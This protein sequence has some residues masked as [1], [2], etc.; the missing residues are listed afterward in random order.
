[1]KRGAARARSVLS[2]AAALAFPYLLFEAQ[3]LRR[4][5]CKVVLPDL[6]EQLEGLVIVQLSDMHVGFQPSLNLRALRKAFAIARAAAPDLIVITGDLAC[7]AGRLDELKAELAT[8]AAPL[9][10]FAV[11]GNHDHGET[12]TPGVPPVDFGDLGQVGV[13]MLVNEAITVEHQGAAV[14][15][16]GIDDWEHGYADLPAVLAQLDRRPTTLRLL[17]SHYAEA[18]LAASPGDFALTLS[19]DTHGGQI[20]LPWFGGRIMLSEPLAQFRDGLY[21]IDGRRLY[22][23]RGIGT[24]FLPLRFLCRPEVVVFHLTR[25]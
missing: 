20:C 7:G 13:R 21:Q 9:G 8:L 5:D 12:K 23:T 24:S 3:W 2:A 10:V 1:M 14:Q 19:G 16:C 25:G 18:A 4:V 22:V 17:L 11:Y 6:A 15:L